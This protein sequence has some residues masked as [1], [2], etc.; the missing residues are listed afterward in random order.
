M[1]YQKPFVSKQTVVP[2]G[3]NIQVN[4]YA[5]TDRGWLITTCPMEQRN[6]VLQNHLIQLYELSGQFRGIMV[7]LYRE[8]TGMYLTSEIWEAMPERERVE[9]CKNTKFKLTQF[10]FV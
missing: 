3:R 2:D 10:N 4:T 9:W 8:R 5:G 1:T 7:K 6:I